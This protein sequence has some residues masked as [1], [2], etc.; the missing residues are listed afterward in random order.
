M[1][2]D[3]INALC[4]QFITQLSPSKI[5]LFGSYAEGTN[6][7]QSDF[8]FYIVMKDGTENLVDLT[9]QAYR[10][11]RRIKQRPVDIIVGTESRFNERKEQ[12]TVESEV[13]RKGVLLMDKVFHEWLSFAETDLGVARHLYESFH[14]KPLEIICYHCQQSAEKAIKA[15]I[16]W[17]LGRNAK[18]A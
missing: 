4:D 3:E 15:V 16:I 10:S 6:H 9:S 11:I 14:P 1:P 2:V 12:P 17:I 13:Y 18:A 7:E 8:D 5:Y